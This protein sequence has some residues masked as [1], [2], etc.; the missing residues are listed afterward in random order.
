ME[1]DCKARRRVGRGQGG[2][3]G[4]RAAGGSRGGLVLFVHYFKHNVTSV[5]LN[6]TIH[7]ETE[8]RRA[9]LT[10]LLCPKA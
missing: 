4:R 9:I 3:E 2:A 6:Q 7:S 1:R 8:L 5:K 10:Y